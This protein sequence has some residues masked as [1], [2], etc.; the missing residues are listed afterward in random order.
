MENSKTTEFTISPEMAGSRLDRCLADL[1]PGSSRSFLQKLVKDGRVLADGQTVTLPRMAVKSGMRL[2]VIIPAPPDTAP[3]PEPFEF[4][5]IYEDH[6]MLV[7][8]KPFGVVVHPAAGNHTGTVVNALLGRYP[9][10]SQTFCDS[11]GRPG[12]VHRLDKDT[13]GCL[14]IAKTP[15]ALYKLGQA[16]AEHT[17]KKCYIAVCRGIPERKRGELTTLIG[18]HPVNRQKMAIVERNGKTAITAYEIVG[19]KTINGVPLALAKVN[20]AT[21]RTHQIR[22]HMASLHLPVV[23]DALY[24]RHP[25][26]PGVE[27]QLLHA[28]QLS[29]PHP[30]TGEMMKFT[31]RLPEDIRS[32]ASQIVPEEIL[33]TL[34]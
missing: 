24:N 5:I 19:T 30:E 14:A 22:V 28:W 6:C 12:I 8:D 25:A 4:D 27:R 9:Q 10:L 2:Q 3:A 11:D 15:D 29:L 31:S 16:F 26:F 34:C 1:I 18:R 20:I 13:S 23:G 33:N 17:A 7:I 32:V 21:G